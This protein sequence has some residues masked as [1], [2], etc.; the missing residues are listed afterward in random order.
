MSSSLVGKYEYYWKQ[1][2]LLLGNGEGE[3]S[4]DGALDLYPDLNA[5]WLEGLLGYGTPGKFPVFEFGF[6]AKV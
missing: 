6:G 2:M 5:A 3:G 1:E 4:G